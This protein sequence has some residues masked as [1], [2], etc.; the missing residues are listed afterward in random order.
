MVEGCSHNLHLIRSAV[1]GGHR[2][3][4]G[5][6]FFGFDHMPFVM[7]QKNWPGNFRRTVTTGKKGKEY[8]RALEFS[9]GVPVELS[10]AEVDA[11]RGDIGVSLQP[12]EFDEK[13]RPRVITDDVI[14]EDT[15]QDSEAN[16]PEQSH[17]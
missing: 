13:A 7:L 9:P 14:A 17:S 15:A 12:I 16:E 8:R 11:L 1:P 10:A 2:Q 3:Y 4:G 5:G 6:L